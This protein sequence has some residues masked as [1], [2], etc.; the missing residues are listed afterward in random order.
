MMRITTLLVALAISSLS[1]PAAAADPGLSREAVQS[2]M[3]RATPDVL[4]CGQ[5]QDDEVVAK[6]TITPAGTVRRVTIEGA[7]AKSALGKCMKQRLAAVQFPKAEKSTPV[8]YPFQLWA[9]AKAQP[10]ARVFA[11]RLARADLDALL[12]VLEGDLKKCGD[13]TARATFQIEPNGKP[14]DVVVQEVDEKTSDCV[15]KRIS[16]VRFPQ[17]SGATPVDRSFKLQEP[18]ADEG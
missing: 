7:H 13:G 10:A 16:R 12:N 4:A 3:K 9:S 1:L 15:T 18:A 11:K 8:R 5:G 14:K 17:A 2:T 6:F